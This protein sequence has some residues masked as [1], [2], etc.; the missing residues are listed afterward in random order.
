MPTIEVKGLKEFERTLL[1]LQEEFGTT[2]AKRA[3]VPALRQAMEATRSRI[4]A[5]APVDTGKLRTKVRRGAK[6]ATGKDKRKKYLSP[7]TIAFGYVDVGVNYKDQKGQ[8][9]PAAEAM[10]F[11]TAEVAGRPFIRQGFE[12]TA[13]QM[14]ASLAEQLGRNLDAWAAK[15]RAKIPK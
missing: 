3:L 10:E 7:N 14:L 6:V 13:P 11:G 5:G 12:S 4:K 2:R 8:Y 15:Q 9:R 1:D